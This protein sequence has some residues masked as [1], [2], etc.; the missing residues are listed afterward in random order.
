MTKQEFLDALRLLDQTGNFNVADRGWQ[1]VIEFS[2]GIGLSVV[3]GS[4]QLDDVSSLSIP[5][6]AN[7]NL[8]VVGRPGSSP[9]TTPF[10]MIT[11]VSGIITSP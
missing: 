1:D 9:M 10:E 2:V 7:A 11:A 3:I 4:L 5:K 6:A 8:L